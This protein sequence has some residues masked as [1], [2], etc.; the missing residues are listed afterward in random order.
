M[1]SIYAFKNYKIEK[2]IKEIQKELG[3]IDDDNFDKMT[4]LI[5]EQIQL[6]HV[7]KA[8]SVK[9]GRIILK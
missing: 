1:S 4:D 3:S 5:S 9:L 7:K 2:R 8:L 6:E